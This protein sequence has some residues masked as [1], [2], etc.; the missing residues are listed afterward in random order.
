M[1]DRYPVNR[2]KKPEG[3]ACLFVLARNANAI[4]RIAV[5]ARHPTVELQL[6][7]VGREVIPRAVEIGEGVVANRINA[8]TAFELDV[9]VQQRL[10]LRGSK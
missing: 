7:V 8:N 9:A 5:P 1:F 4:R 3:A 2:T 6:K 10:T